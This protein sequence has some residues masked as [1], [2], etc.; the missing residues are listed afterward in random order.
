M[1]NFIKKPNTEDNR[2]S[3]LSVSNTVFDTFIQKTIYMY[4]IVIQADLVI[5]G[6]GIRCYD[7]LRV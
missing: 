5:Y 4:Y 2:G 6:H 3:I 1:N 7:Y